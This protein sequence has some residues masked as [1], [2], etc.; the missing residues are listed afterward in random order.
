MNPG[1]I[2]T[3]LDVQVLLVILTIF[4][5]ES[6][7]V[8]SEVAKFEVVKAIELT[9]TGKIEIEAV[10]TLM[11]KLSRESYALTSIS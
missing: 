3:R 4:D 1:V 9:V 11:I 7:D 5:P 8:A 10:F 6:V 2:V